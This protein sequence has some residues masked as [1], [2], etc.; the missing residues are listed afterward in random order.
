MKTFSEIVAEY[1]DS[2]DWVRDY[3]KNY[4]FAVAIADVQMSSIEEL[5][6]KIV[7]R[8]WACVDENKVQ[9]IYQKLQEE[10]K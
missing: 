1:M 6:D 4:G 2:Q 3:I 5:E 10:R 9:N 7:E 8:A